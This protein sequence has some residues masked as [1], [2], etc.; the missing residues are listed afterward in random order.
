MRRTIRL[1]LVAATLATATTGFAGRQEAPVDLSQLQAPLYAVEGDAFVRHNGDRYCNRPL[2]CDHTYAVALGGD[3]PVAM[4]GD[5]KSILGNLMFALV[6]QNRGTWL[7]NASDITSKYRPGRMEWIVQDAAWGRTT[8]HLEVVPAA[9]GAGMIARVAVENSLPGDLLLWASGGFSNEKGGILGTMD[10]TSQTVKYMLGGFA[11]ADCEHNLVQAQGNSWTLQTATGRSQNAALGSCS[12][13]TKT[14]VA[15]AGAWQD[16][17]ALLASRGNALPIACGTVALAGHQAVYW[18]LGGSPAEGVPTRK[19][20][21]EEFATGMRRVT[22]IEQ[23]VVVE[24]PDPWLN[25]A[26]GASVIANDAHFRDGIYTHSGMRW[27][28]PLLG[29]RTVYGG[30]VFGWHDDVKTDAR[31]FIRHQ[32]TESDHTAAHADPQG[33]AVQPGAGLAH[34][35]Q[36]PHRSSPP[37]SLRHA[38][39]V[40]RSGPT[41]VALDR[42][43]GTGKTPASVAGFALRIYQGLL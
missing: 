33:L 13:E 29:W 30:T 35:R 32:I 5:A 15:D 27:G 4:V 7:Q 28:V 3:K 8:I 14:V 34:V 18:G 42:R 23:Q 10:M 9:Q 20:L 31:N 16:P 39:P 1:A 37:A 21:A 38:K 26:V 17:V 22:A 40:L 24:T 41:C 36:R 12:A 6:R 2:Y 19:P 11:A 25:A 43:S